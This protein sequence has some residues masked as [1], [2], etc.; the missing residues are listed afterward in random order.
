MLKKELKEVLCHRESGNY[1]CHMEKAKGIFFK[2]LWPC[3]L[4]ASSVEN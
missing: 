3:F 1:S 2:I 4:K